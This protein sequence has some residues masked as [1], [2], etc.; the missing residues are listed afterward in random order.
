[1][2]IAGDRDHWLLQD[3]EPRKAGVPGARERPGCGQVQ[4]AETGEAGGGGVGGRPAGHA[5]APRGVLVRDCAQA[6]VRAGDVSRC[7]GSRHAAASARG[8]AGQPGRIQDRGL[9]EILPDAAGDPLAQGAENDVPAVAVAVGAAGGEQLPD[10]AQS[11]DVTLTA[12]VQ[13]DH[14][15]A[16]KAAGVAEQLRDGDAV[17]SA[18]CRGKLGQVARCGLPQRAPAT[19]R[20]G[21]PQAPGTGD[22]YRIC[23]EHFALAFTAMTTGLVP[24]ILSALGTSAPALHTAILERNS[25]AS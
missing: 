24:P 21:T 17:P 15:I 8:G 11:A 22:I 2:L 14:G 4:G 19:R 20:P 18:A 23:A 25:Q 6:A 12:V 5:A 13:V 10:A 3:A 7:D 1:V 9:D 16:V